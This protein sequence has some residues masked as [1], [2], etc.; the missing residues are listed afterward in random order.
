MEIADLENVWVV[1][2][3][4]ESDLP[5]IQV[6]QKL[7]FTAAS[8]PGSEFTSAISFIDPII[9][10]QTRTA[11][12]RAEVNNLQQMLKPGMFVRG[13]IAAAGSDKFL[14]IPKTSVLWTGKRS[15][16]YVKVPDQEF[17]VF[18]MREIT[19]GASPGQ[20]FIAEA[21]LMEGE[22]IVTNGVFAIDAAAQ[23]SGNY[24]MM[25]RGADKTIAVPDLF[26]TQL[27]G[28]VNRYFELKNSLVESAFQPAQSNAFKLDSAL[29][30]IEMNLLDDEAHH[31]WMQQYS[32]LK[33]Q[34]ER[35][36][37]ADDIGQQ[38]DVFSA[39]SNALIEALEQFE[40]KRE[41]VFVAYCPM[42]LDDKG[43]YWASEFE[44]IKNPYFGD[45]MLGCG[46]V[47]KTISRKE[48]L[49]VKTD[50]HRGHQH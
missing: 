18:E 45:A 10:P 36:V 41:I 43:A 46:E 12:V 27:T 3:A 22:E 17:P 13:M 30:K 34:I 21:G 48:K 31:I 35:L 37:K 23:L 32:E 44:E 24:S 9:N 2:D 26:T 50:P 14:I 40:V 33:Q 8:I 20:Y 39:L 1:L 38:R 25:N 19:L 29:S 5:F 4:Y 11:S 28:F 15:V 16:V 6:G 7:V 47:E 42:A 49:D